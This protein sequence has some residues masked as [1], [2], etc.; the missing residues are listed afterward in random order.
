MKRLVTCCLFL[1]TSGLALSQELTMS[2]LSDWNVRLSEN[3]LRAGED[4]MST[5]TSGED[6]SKITIEVGPAN[7]YYLF[8]NSWSLS[9]ERSGGNWDNDLELY[10]RRTGSG[11]SAGF[12]FANISGG[13]SFVRINRSSREFFRGNGYRYD[14]PI[15]LEIR[16]ISLTIPTD[17]Y[18]TDLI[19]TVIDN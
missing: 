19:F 16:G 12:F 3:D 2:P 15:Q 18:S 4:F 7:F 6:Q 10:I 5:M 17:T 14:V 13:E 11:Q 1:L 8:F 9:V